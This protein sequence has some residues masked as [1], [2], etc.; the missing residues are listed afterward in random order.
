[1]KN[2]IIFFCLVV[3]LLGLFLWIKDQIEDNA[4]QKEALEKVCNKT[5]GEIFIGEGTLDS[6]NTHP[7]I[8]GYRPIQNVTG[9]FNFI[10]PSD[11]E[12]PTPGTD[13]EGEY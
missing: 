11:A 5:E 8:V 1:M 3:N 12:D 2:I 7:P 10:L 6:V 9:S 13:T 4:I